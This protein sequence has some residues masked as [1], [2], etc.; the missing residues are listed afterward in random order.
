MLEPF[1]RGNNNRLVALL[2]AISHKLS[3]KPKL[4]ACN[5]GTRNFQKMNLPRVPFW[6]ACAAYGLSHF[7][8]RLCIFR[9]HGGL[10][11][12]VSGGNPMDLCRFCLLWLRRRFVLFRCFLCWRNANLAGRFGVSSRSF[13]LVV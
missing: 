11:P 13:R 7:L 8:I 3:L 4:C 1:L 6:A 10:D 5:L 9:R 12:I 2:V